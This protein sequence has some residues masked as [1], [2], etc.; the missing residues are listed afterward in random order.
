[1]ASKPRWPPGGPGESPRQECPLHRNDFI[2]P[3]TCTAESGSGRKLGTEGET[4]WERKEDVGD[5]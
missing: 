5:I 4:L 3:L 1:M 2:L